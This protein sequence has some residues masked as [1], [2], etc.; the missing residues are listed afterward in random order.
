MTM[1]MFCLCVKEVS[2]SQPSSCIAFSDR[3]VVFASDKFYTIS[4]TGLTVTGLTAFYFTVFML[5]T[6]TF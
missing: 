1:T 2:I 5:S 4:F 3:G 6:A